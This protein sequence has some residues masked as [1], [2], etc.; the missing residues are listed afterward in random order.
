M[1]KRELAKAEVLAGYR[2]GLRNGRLDQCAYREQS[3][4]AL[5]EYGFH[6]GQIDRRKQLAK[7]ERSEYSVNSPSRTR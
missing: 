4:F 3:R 1:T 2:C 5:F 7:G 6:A